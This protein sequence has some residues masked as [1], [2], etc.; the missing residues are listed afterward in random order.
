MSNIL[1]Q[2]CL[3]MYDLSVDTNTKRLI[4]GK[5]RISASHSRDHFESTF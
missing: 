4:F 2:V 5:T 3:S 1:K